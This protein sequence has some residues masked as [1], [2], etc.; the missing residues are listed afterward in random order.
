[1]YSPMEYSGDNFFT[2]I[3]VSFSKYF[4][5]KWNFLSIDV[6]NG[7]GVKN[8]SENSDWIVHAGYSPIRHNL[9]N[10]PPFNSLLINI[11]ASMLK[12]P[13]DFG[14]NVNSKLHSFPCSNV[15]SI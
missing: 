5:I 7:T 6:F 10:I 4:I 3:T 8:I 2:R 14:W 13:R 15:H 1:M 11:G 12:F 9:L